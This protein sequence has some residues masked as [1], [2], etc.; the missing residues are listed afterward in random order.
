MISV[1]IADDQELVRAGFE[2]ILAAQDDI[3]VVAEAADGR[4]AVAAARDHRPDVLLLDI[5]MPG[6]D[7]L[8]AL[9]RILAAS[10]PTRVVILTTFDADEYVYE[11]L[12]AGASG[13]LLKGIRREQL[14]DAVRVAARGDALL[15]P[16]V[17]RRL[18]DGLVASKPPKPHVNAV[19]TPREHEVL[20]ALARGRTNAEIAAELFISEHTV[21]THVA[22][23]LMKLGLRDRVHA[24]IHAY[25]T[26]VVRP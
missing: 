23:V 4:E 14:V 1:V 17:T 18:I 16:A 21:K 2:A 24:V 22:N 8:T 13:F 6:H 12:R 20:L 10:P 7:G 26:G 25:E 3:E 19:L 5:R 9:P 11:A 15:D